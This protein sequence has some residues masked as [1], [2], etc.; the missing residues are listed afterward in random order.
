MPAEHDSLSTHGSA[1]RHPVEV[2]VLRASPGSLTAH[3]PWPAYTTLRARGGSPYGPVYAFRMVLARHA[4]V[5]CRPALAPGCRVAAAVVAY[6]AAARRASGRLRMGRWT[7]PR[8]DFRIRKFAETI[9][10]ERSRPS[11][12]GAWALMP[13]PSRL[14]L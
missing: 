7:M 14:K 9:E 4:W 6:P 3:H 2:V 12:A 11:G 1:R 8:F 5:D 10:F 13:L